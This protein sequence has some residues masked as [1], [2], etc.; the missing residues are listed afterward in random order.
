MIKNII[1][2]IVILSSLIVL[3]A[4]GNWQ[5]QRAKWKENIIEKLESEYAKNPTEHRLEFSNL[6]NPMIQYGH[7]RGKFDYSKQMLFGPKKHEENIGYDVLIPMALTKG[8]N[9]LVNMGWVK[10]ENRDDIKIPSLKG[11]ITITGIA[12]L[13]E[14]NSFTPNNSPENNIWTKLD[15][16]QIESA[17]N[18]KTLAPVI[19]FAEKASVTFTDF[20]MQT[21]RWMPRNKHR[22]YALFWFSMAGILLIIT[23]IF[24]FRYKNKN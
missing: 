24:I 23:G 19:F 11:Y 9:V 13:P 18:I 8:G 14:W 1:G 2:G 3:C 4:L 5:L 21:E 6:Q 10:G 22:Q 16:E 7:I 17:K 20:I 15:L 12:R